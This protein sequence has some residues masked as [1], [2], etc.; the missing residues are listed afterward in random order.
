MAFSAMTELGENTN[1]IYSFWHL[2]GQQQCFKSPQMSLIFFYIKLQAFLNKTKMEK[3][4]VHENS[5]H[6]NKPQFKGVS[7]I[8]IEMII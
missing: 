6:L 4:T 8:H 5:I 1:K 3:H 7:L 2:C